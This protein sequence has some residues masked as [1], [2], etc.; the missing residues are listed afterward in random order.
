MEDWHGCRLGRSESGRGDFIFDRT[1]LHFLCRECLS[2]WYRVP[3]GRELTEN[4]QERIVRELMAWIERQ[5]END[6]GNHSP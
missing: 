4:E 6:A 2:K 3:S 5:L 1:C